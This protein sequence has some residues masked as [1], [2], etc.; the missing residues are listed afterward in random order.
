[1]PDWKKEIR[2]RL[3]KLRLS[4]MREAEIVEELAQHIND[5]YEELR[6]DGAT[7]EVAARSALAE[8]LENDLLLSELRRVERP[9]VLREPVMS[10]PDG[11]RHLHADLWQDLRYGLRAMSKAPGFTLV[12]VLALALGIGANTAIFTVVNA[13]LLRPLPYPGS[14]KLVELG[15]AFPANEFGGNLSEPK[16]V[17]LHDQNQSFEAITATQEIGSNTFLS[18]DAQTEYLRGMIVSADF[19]RVMGVPPARGREFTKE[20]DSPAGPRVVILGDGLWRRRFGSDVGIVGKTILF[21]GKASTVVGIMPPGFDYFGPQDVFVPMGLNPASRNEG[22]NWTV[23]GRLKE[24]VTTEQM[25]AEM[26]LLFE[27]FRAT[28][29]K[30]AQQNETFGAR[31]WRVNMTG[32]VRELLWILLGAVSLVLLIACANVANLQLTRAATRQKEMAIRMAMGGGS[33]RLIRQLLTEGLLLALMGGC[34][35]LLLAIWGLDAMRKLLPEGLIPRADEIS[36]DWRVLAFCLSVSLLTG[37]VFSLAPA[38]RILR[39][40]VNSALKEGSQKSGAARGRLRSVLVVVEVAL[41][42]TLTAGAGLLFRTFANLRSV[43]PGFEARNLVSFGISPQGK[44]YDT[45]A[46]IN[47]LYLRGLERFRSLPGVEAAA[48]TNKLPLDSQ[49]NLPFKLAGQAEFAGAVQYRLVTPDYFK[50][51]KMSLRHGRQFDQNDRA[52]AEPVVIVNEAF[53]HQRLA[54]GEPLGQE[55]C[56]GC[57]NFDPA[58]RRI[59]GVVNDTKQRSL[60]EAAPAAIFI[61]LQ[62]APEQ[63]KAIL[64][65]SIFV[66]RTSGDPLLLSAAIR[67]ETRQLDP[68]LP[69]RDL[70]SMEQLISRSV[71]PQRF[72]L[73]LLSLFSG[74]GL[75]LSA[76][77]IYGVMAYTVS[78]RTHEIGLRMALG[79]QARDVLRL[80]LKQGMTLALAGVGI[81]LMATFALTRLMKN[82]LFGVSATDPA[83][84]AGVTLLLISAALLACYIPARRATKVDPV[85]A[86]RHE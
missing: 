22:H 34:G 83:T 79:A 48:I 53:V 43:E 55:L 66:L 39:V 44:N 15:R 8:F 24:A 41:A 49:F 54:D 40:D 64:R 46:K 17:F 6:A 51:M 33:W 45:A 78:Q 84:L 25:R 35:G 61:P 19:F 32:S 13:V 9:P 23:I 36:L 69:V 4:P 82:L 63:L 75:L 67:S 68:G 38:W 29:P 2:Q 58:M 73:S 11:A 76:V 12:A 1:M 5:R 71:A 59:V 60:A 27:K 42:L 56:I 62:Q 18:G 28:Y 7:R 37:I 31:S 72:N 57:E 3:A 30:Q 77:G 16:F 20:E 65:Q 47:D 14:E 50:V 70:R 26:N 85:V 21:N 52:G 81:G 10:R 74:L 80:V 86:L